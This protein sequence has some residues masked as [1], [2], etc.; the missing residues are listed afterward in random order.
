MKYKILLK[1][2]K[3]INV[4]LLAF[5]LLFGIFLINGSIERVAVKKEINNF[6][7]RAVYEEKIIINGQD[8][9]VYKV[10]VKYEYEDVNRPVFTRVVENN[11]VKY[12]IGGKTDITLTSRNPFRLIDS[13]FVQDVTGMFSNWLY[14]GHAT[15]NTTDNGSHYIESVGNQKERN[16]VSEVESTW[17]ETEL[18]SGVDTNEIICLRL[19]NTTPEMRDKMV[20]DLRSKIGLKYNYNFFINHRKKYYC[21]DLITRTTDKFGIDIN[22]DGL[23]AIGNDIILSKNTYIIFF[24]E[25][26]EK[27]VFHLYYLG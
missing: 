12:F 25:R 22:Y 19:K 8:V 4:I 17:I 11:E 26:I 10:N 14:I 24:L 13:S 9:H 27:G 18:R 7:K 16:G 23:L 5:F 1:I 6:K 15:M 20:E 3:I 21:T 2:V